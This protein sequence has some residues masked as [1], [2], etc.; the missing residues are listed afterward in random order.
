MTMNDVIKLP[1]PPADKAT[2]APAA[3]NAAP[4]AIA[5]GAKSPDNNAAEPKT[6]AVK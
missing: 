3:D 5:P 1:S 6:P 4:Q 2:A